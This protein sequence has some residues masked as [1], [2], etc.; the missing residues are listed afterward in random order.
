MHYKFEKLPRDIL[1]NLF[2]ILQPKALDAVSATCKTFY[3]LIDESPALFHKK[4]LKAKI[5]RMPIR[6]LNS[7]ENNN[8]KAPVKLKNFIH[9]LTSHLYKLDFHSITY[10]NLPNDCVLLKKMTAEKEALLAQLSPKLLVACYLMQ[11]RMDTSLDPRMT[12][13]L[14]KMIQLIFNDLTA[15]EK[16]KNLTLFKTFSSQP[17]TDLEQSLYSMCEMHFYA[18]NT[19]E[20]CY[21][22]KPPAKFCLVM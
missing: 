20:D 1:L 13:C 11:F 21:D 2:R 18:R 14:I 9:N 15:A 22:F 3:R 17:L 6:L 10:N 5:C 12:R 19:I 8:K 16:S 7:L 4:G